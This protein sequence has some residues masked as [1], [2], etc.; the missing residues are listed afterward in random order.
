MHKTADV[1]KATGSTDGEGRESHCRR[2]EEGGCRNQG[3]RD[4]DK[5]DDSK[6]KKK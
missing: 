3:C 5:K 2:R 4:P 1:A 6:D